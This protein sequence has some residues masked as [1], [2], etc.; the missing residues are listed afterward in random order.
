MAISIDLLNNGVIRSF[1]VDDV[2]SAGAVVVEHGLE[3]AR[4]AVEEVL[5]VDQG[6]VGAEA[7][8]GL[9]GP[10]TAEAAQAG[11]RDLGEGF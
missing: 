4:V 7:Q 3:G 2:E 6:V 5:V 8:D 1:L 10:R 9:V 11:V